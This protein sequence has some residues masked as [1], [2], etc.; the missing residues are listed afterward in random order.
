MVLENDLYKLFNWFTC[1]DMVVNPNKFQL[2][3]LR[4][5]RKQRLRIN[6]NGVEILAKK[7]VKLLGIEIDNKLK[8]DRH[9]KALCQKVDKKSSDFARLNMYIS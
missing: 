3:L 2:M 4:V 8:F 5:K 7:L 9:V 6:M 1:N